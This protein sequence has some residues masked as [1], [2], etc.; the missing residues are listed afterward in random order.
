MPDPHFLV[1]SFKIFGI[2]VQNWV[3]VAVVAVA[4]ALL[5]SL[6]RSNRSNDS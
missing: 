2:E 1:D 6:R 5:L 4:L 3:V